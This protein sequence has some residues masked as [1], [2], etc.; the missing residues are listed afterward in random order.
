MKKI[1][2]TGGTGLVGSLLSKL[3]IEKGHQVAFLSRNKKNIPNIKVYEW[4]IEKQFIE[5]EALETADVIVHLAGTG[6]ADHRWTDAYKKDILESRTLSTQLLFNELQKLQKRPEA[7]V[8][9]SAVGIYGFDSGTRLVVED[10]EQ[11]KDFLADVTKK[12]EFEIDKIAELG[13]RVAKMR[14]GIVLSK[15]GGALPKL[16]KPIEL[17]AGAALAS[18]EQ[19]MSWIHEKDL[20]KMFI[21]AIENLNIQGAYNAV[22]VEAVTNQALTTAVAKVLDKPLILP[23]V[24]SFVLKLMFG[25]MAQIVIGGNKVSSEKIQKAG[26][27]FEFKNLEIA[28]RDLL[29]K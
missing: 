8:S 3:L 21:Y 24:P 20:S 11:G 23:N 18:G 16:M 5:N 1:L 14:I 6:V 9:A 13:I 10:S 15:N 17:Y 27:E 25:E 19:L 2:I 4:N 7:F 26:F 29:L 12:W 28:L 22:G